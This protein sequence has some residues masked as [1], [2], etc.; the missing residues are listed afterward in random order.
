[1]TSRLNGREIKFIRDELEKRFPEYCAMCGKTPKEL[2][3]KKLELHET[4]YER[5]LISDNF[6]W[7]CKGCNHL[8]P[9][10]KE[11]IVGTSSIT[12]EHKKNIECEPFFRRWLH[13]EI[14]KPENNFHLPYYE[15]LAWAAY[16]VGVSI[17]TI[18]RRYLPVLTDH[19]SS[20]YVT[21]ADN[22]GQMKIW[23]RGYEPEDEVLF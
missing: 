10:R 14:M 19:P 8:K 11:Q 4:K 12:A 22:L 17:D 7:L 5:P 20:P 13:G 15:T 9:L 16:E 2:H 1:M 23:V 18:S 6:I 21:K 3:V